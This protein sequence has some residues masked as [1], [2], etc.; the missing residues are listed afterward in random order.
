[1]APPRANPHGE[2]GHNTVTCVWGAGKCGIKQE[3]CRRTSQGHRR[4]AGRKHPGVGRTRATHGGGRGGI[5][6]EAAWLCG[7]P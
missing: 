6:G 5:G 2:G 3:G 1:M 4:A 7:V